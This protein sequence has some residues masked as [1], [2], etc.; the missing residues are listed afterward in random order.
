MT[1]D[2]KDQIHILMERGIQPVSAE[3]IARHRALQTSF[4]GK[5]ARP[6]IR[7]RRLAAI[8]V[9]FA[10]AGCAAALVATQLGGPGASAGGRPVHQA[11]THQTPAVLTAAAVR[12][13]ASASR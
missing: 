1:T 6:A 11:R 10:A 12:H 7:T 9:G 4:P 3:D 2:L 5:S 8:A 13:L